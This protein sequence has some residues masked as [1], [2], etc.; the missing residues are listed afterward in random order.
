MLMAAGLAQAQVVI[1]RGGPGVRMT[2]GGAAPG[3]LGGSPADFGVRA[4]R[5]GE[6]ARY[7]VITAGGP[8]PITQIRTVS[9]VGQQGERFWV[10]TQD[11][12]AGAMST[13]GPIRKLLIAFGAIREAVGTEAYTLLS[14]SSVRRETLVRAGSGDGP[15]GF[16]FPRGWERVGEEEVA[17]PAGSLKAVHWRKGDEHL[18][19]SAEAGPMGVVK[20]Q[21]ADVTIDLGSR[22]TGAKS[23]I[24]FGG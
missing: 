10:E 11:E 13:R 6:W 15:A 20:Y 8:M 3:P 22:G 7:S 19:T 17:V 12:F 24:P 9:V 21:S 18:W 23:R 1:Q 5:V 4:W 14:D 16:A 2:M